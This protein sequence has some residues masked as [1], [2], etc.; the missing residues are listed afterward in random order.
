MKNKK[1]QFDGLAFGL[2]MAIFFVTIIG[3]I[4]VIL[5]DSTTF[6]GKAEEKCEKLN[7]ELFEY[8]VGSLF[9]SSSITCWNPETKEIKIIK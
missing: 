8:S 4:G 6:E 2:T 1:G 5:Y 3:L 9:T 7:M